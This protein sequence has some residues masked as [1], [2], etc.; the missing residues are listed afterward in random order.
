[1]GFGARLAGG[2]TS[3]HGMSGGC[4]FPWAHGWPRSC[5]FIG[6]GGYRQPHVRPLGAN[7]NSITWRTSGPN[8]G[9]TEWKAARSVAEGVAESVRSRASA[10]DH[11]GLS[12]AWCIRLFAF[13]VGLP[14]IEVLMGRCCLP[15]FTIDENHAH[16]KIATGMIGILSAAAQ[17]L[18]ELHVNCRLRGQYNRRPDFW[19]GFGLLSYCPGTG[20]GSAKVILMPSGRCFWG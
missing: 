2:C 19:I 15:D 14:I 6:G 12:L 20:R 5:F 4:R 18:V 8:R 9:N 17:G 13:K 10:L 16:R 11:V 7:I 3:G 1:M